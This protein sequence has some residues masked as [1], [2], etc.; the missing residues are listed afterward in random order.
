MRT[1]GPVTSFR[2]VAVVACGF[3]A[4]VLIASYIA[5]TVYMANPWPWLELVHESGDRTLIG[6]IFYF[7]HAARELPLDLL[8]GVAVGGSVLF[9]FRVADGADAPRRQTPLVG[10]AVLI[11][12]IV[13]GTLWTGGWAM[14][15]ENLLQYPT[16]PGEPP[17]W[18]G[19]WRYHF[20]S[21]IMLMSVSFGVAGQAVL[22]T[23][24]L[25]GRGN[26]VGLRIY[27]AAVVAFAT[28]AV[29]FVPGW[30][31]FV[32]PVFLGHQLRE[33]FTHLM[34]TLPAAWGVCLLLFEKRR[35]PQGDQGTV[36]LRGP[37]ITGALGTLIGA[38]LL[39]GS[40]ATSAASQG[41]TE[42]L[43]TLIFPHFFEH[44]FSYGVV[45]AAAA[46][47]VEWANAW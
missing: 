28:L 14:L 3:S 32:N 4:A 40:L 10:L 23:R 1:R 43:S 35:R 15:V 2:R 36:G 8:L 12:L 27:G 9:A 17:Q 18:G 25:T 21:H 24:G 39:A 41:Q 16:R 30:D 31:S 26:E 5:I 6:T 47:A 7:E 44:M 34:V 11:A 45:M 33:A 37:F 46:S 19:H 22:L 29:V 20:L 13:G 38:F 42:S